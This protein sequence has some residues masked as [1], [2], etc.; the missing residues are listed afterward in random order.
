LAAKLVAAQAIVWYCNVVLGNGAL[1]D[2]VEN[3]KY[4]EAVANDAGK[5]NAIYRD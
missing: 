2:L 4:Q 5:V 1:Y 3:V